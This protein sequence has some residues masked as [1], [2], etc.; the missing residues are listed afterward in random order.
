[1]NINTDE[2]DDIDYNFYESDYFPYYYT[3][4]LL[5]A[6]ILMFLAI[7]IFRKKRDKEM[8]E[9]QNEMSTNNQ[10]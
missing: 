7:K 2:E 5:L 3:V 1:M 9:F 6:L 8:I 4:V 10:I